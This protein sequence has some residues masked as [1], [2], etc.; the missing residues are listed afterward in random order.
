METITPKSSP[1]SINQPGLFAE[2][3]RTEDVKLNEIEKEE[4][5]EEEKITSTKEVSFPLDI[6]SRVIY[7][8]LLSNKLFL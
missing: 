5:K 1:N 7:M 3:Q 8:V 2:E 6:Y 4:Q